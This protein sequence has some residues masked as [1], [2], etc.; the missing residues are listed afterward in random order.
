MRLTT[1]FSCRHRN[2]YARPEEIIIFHVSSAK[3]A[4]PEQRGRKVVPYDP[5]WAWFNELPS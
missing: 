1:R 3:Q 4:K 5:E 2:A